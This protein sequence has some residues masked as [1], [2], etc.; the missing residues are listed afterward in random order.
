[1]TVPVPSNAQSSLPDFLLLLVDDDSKAIESYKNKI[2]EWFGNTHAE[3]KMQIVAAQSVAEALKMVLRDPFDLILT[4]N[5]FGDGKPNGSVLV[6]KLRSRS[7]YT[8]IVYYTRLPTIPEDI[9]KKVSTAGFTYIVKDDELVATTEGVIEDRLSRLEK[10][11]FLRGMVISAFIDIEGELNDLLLRYF[12]L[13][14]NR[15]P[16]FRTSILE[17]RNMSFRTKLDAL[18]MIMFGKL[19]PNKKENASKPFHKLESNAIKDGIQNLRDIE[20]QRNCLAHC[21]ILPEDKLQLVSM[22]VPLVYTR[23]DIKSIL[24]Q[25]RE[26]S[27]FLTS[28]DACLAEEAAAKGSSTSKIAKATEEPAARTKTA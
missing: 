7:T 28:L 16:T 19:R 2:E 8:D 9:Q 6:E 23:K 17:N 18:I 5:N 1:M 13:N 20:E 25:I 14:S 27:E 10:V 22:G 26:C 21:V 11:S 3:M 12:P 15:E 24:Q 4:D